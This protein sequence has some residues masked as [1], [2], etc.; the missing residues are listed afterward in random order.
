MI[1]FKKNLNSRHPTLL[2]IAFN[3]NLAIACPSSQFCVLPLHV[4]FFV[5]GKEIAIRRALIPAL[6]SLRKKCGITG[7]VGLSNSILR[8]RPRKYAN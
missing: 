1:I 8:R 5:R 7:E 2:E 3:R 4:Q 6:F